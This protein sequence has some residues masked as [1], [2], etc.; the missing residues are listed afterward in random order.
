L[1]KIVADFTVLHGIAIF[2]QRSVS[3]LVS[4]LVRE[5]FEGVP[6][7]DFL[8]NPQ[9]LAAVHIIPLDKHITN[10]QTAP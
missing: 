3:N 10:G 9:V 2:R 5:R 4:P 6:R 7:R 1:L 8:R